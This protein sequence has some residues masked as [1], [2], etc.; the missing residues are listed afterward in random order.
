RGALSVGDLDGDGTIDLLAGGL[1]VDSYVTGGV[2]VSIGDGTIQGAAQ[3]EAWLIVE[4][5]ERYNALGAMGPVQG[6]QDGD[7][8][9]DLF[10][11]GSDGGYDG[12]YEDRVAAALFLSGTGHGGTVSAGEADVVVHGSLSESENSALSHVDF[13]GDGLTDAFHGD[14]NASA[15]SDDPKASWVWGLS[16][17]LLSSTTAVELGS[18]ED[19]AWSASTSGD[20]LGASLAGS[21]IDGDGYGDVL[22]GAPGLDEGAAGGGGVYLLYGGA[23]WHGESLADDEASLVILGSSYKDQVG[24]VRAEV[25]DI[26]GDSRQDLVIAVPGDA[27]VTVFLDAAS[28]SG[29]LETDEAD[30]FVEGAT[31]A[32]F[33]TSLATG[34]INADGLADLLVGAPG[35]DEPGDAEDVGIVYLFDGST[36]ASGSLTTADVAATIQGT[37]VDEF[38]LGLLA[39]DVD[40]DTQ[41]DILIAAPGHGEKQGR[42]WFFIVP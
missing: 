36:L 15:E 2:Y 29:T 27:Q 40:I 42:I 17:D 35:A 16:G 8:I 33:G 3:D 11:T 18:E 23:S 38:G 21:D 12:S 1:Y 19:A 25:A 26:D 9:D 7:G 28:L 4:G 22:V 31:T 37:D 41:D 34:D 14:W 32:F 13:D 5:E 10:V 39:V 20:Q 6:D 30:T 24:D